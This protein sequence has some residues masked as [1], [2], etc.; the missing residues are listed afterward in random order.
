MVE[1]G[2]WNI[3]T[4]KRGLPK[5]LMTE[6]VNLIVELSHLTLFDIHVQFENGHH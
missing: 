4:K 6:N 1:N 3:P 5:F 2:I